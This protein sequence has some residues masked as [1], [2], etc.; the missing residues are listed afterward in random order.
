MYYAKQTDNGFQITVLAVLF[1]DTSFPDT[2]PDAAWLADSGVYPVEEHLYFDANAFKRNGINPTLRDGVV[3][4][5]ELVALTDDD[6]AQR[7]AD[8]LSQLASVA[9]EQ[10][11]WLLAGCDWTQLGDYEKADQADWAAY[12]KALRDVPKQPGFPETIDWPAAPGAPNLT[13]LLQPGT[14]P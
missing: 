9:R 7:E 5:A 2:G 4:T 1:P 10:R 8:R 13:N 14:L 11:N 3:Y 12:R 6:K